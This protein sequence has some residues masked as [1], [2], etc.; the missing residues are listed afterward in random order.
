MN[1]TKV[2]YT[3]TPITAVVCITVAI[4]FGYAN[5]LLG[6]NATDFH[7]W[8]FLSAHFAHYD[9]THLVLN[10]LALPILLYI[11]PTPIKLYLSGVL[12]AIV[13]IDVYLFFSTIKYYVGFSGLLY[14]IPGSAC[15]RFIAQKQY[16]TA[17]LLVILFGIYLLFTWHVTSTSNG[18]LW[19]PLVPA[20]LLGFIGG[21]FVATYLYCISFLRGDQLTISKANQ[22]PR[23][24]TL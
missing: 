17:L 24:T 9:L 16:G 12:V 7:W 11:F 13:L 4:V 6:Y 2:D 10:L 5:P 19:L 8:Q 3:L 18:K 21:V 20:H 14:V 1:L 15:I 23:K 22:I